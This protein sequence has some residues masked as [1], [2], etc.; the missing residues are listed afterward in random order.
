VTGLRV[1]VGD[2][3]VLRPV[4]EVGAAERFTLRAERAGATNLVVLASGLR[5]SLVAAVGPAGAGA[6]SPCRL[7]VP[8]G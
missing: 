6:T 2:D 1:T 4:P 5:A 3:N 8:G 7:G